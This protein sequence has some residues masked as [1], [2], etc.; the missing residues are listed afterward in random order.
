MCLAVPHTEGNTTL[1]IHANNVYNCLNWCNNNMP[2]PKQNID[3]GNEEFIERCMSDDTMQEYDEEQR[4]AICSLQ[5]REEDRALEDIDTKPTK[6]MANEAEQALEWREEFG[7]GGT[8]VGVARAR[9]IKNRA[10]LSIETIKRMFSY[11]SRHEVDKKA[12]GFRSGE[13]GYPSAGRIAWGLWGGDVGFAWT[14][15]KIDEIAKEEK[16]L[17]L[18]EKEIRAKVGTMI[19][20]G[21]ELPL[22]NTI[23]EAQSEAERL[24]GNGFHEHTMDGEIYY[25]PFESHQQAKEVMEKISNNEHYP[26]HDKSLVRSNNNKEVRTFDVQNLELRMEGDNATVVGYGAVFNSESNDLGGF[27][28]YISPGAFDGRLED[29][30]RFLINHDGLPLARTIN[31]T[32]RLSVDEKGLRYEADLNTKV[33]TANDLIELL[34]DGTISQ[35]SF[36]FTVEDDSWRSEDGKNIRTINKVSRLFDISSV[37]FPA[38]NSAGSYALRSMEQ[39]QEE[40]KKKL[41]ESLVN[42]NKEGIKKEND[43]TKRSLAEMRLKVIKNK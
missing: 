5:L 28:E 18:M 42:E 41:D 1:T 22:Y 6:E 11:F 24:G 9:D 35:S 7:R 23:E 19:S 43:L 15:R 17:E 4:L 40:E 32:L 16:N 10:N 21:I 26:G 39:W 37:T 34:K 29:D 12:E 2:I 31:N 33:S 25:M 3:E 30:V 20:N 36:A 14:K 13:D 8:E 27:Y 38:Y